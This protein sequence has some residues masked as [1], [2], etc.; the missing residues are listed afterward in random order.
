MSIEGVSDQ[1]EAQR[2]QKILSAAG[3]ASRR[4]AEEFIVAGRIHVNG[5]RAVLGDRA[6]ANKDLITLDDVPIMVDESRAYYLLNKPRG[7]ISTVRDTHDRL[8]VVDLLPPEPPVYPIGRL[9]AD[10]EGLLILTNDGEL[11]N[12]LTHPKF[13]VE[14]EYLVLLDRPVQPQVLRAIKVG[15]E[16][17]DGITLPAKVTEL[18]GAGVRITISEGRNRQIRRMFEV[19]N[20]DVIRLIRIRIGPISDPG[21]K[22]GIYRQLKANELRSLWSAAKSVDS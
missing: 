6:I 21:L 5:Q 8:A 2:L 13:K 16:L 17:D 11:T 7:V 4:Q 9:D 14:K 1:G 18:E 19:F 22:S 15:V 10:S 3:L 20:Y 12:R